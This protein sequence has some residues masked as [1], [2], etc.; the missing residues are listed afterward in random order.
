[1]SRDTHSGVQC[2]HCH[3]HLRLVAVPD[4]ASAP[5]PDPTPDPAP[6]PKAD[7]APVT[8]VVHARPAL[9]AQPPREEWTPPPVGEVLAQYAHLSKDTATARRGAARVRASLN[10]ARQ[11]AVKKRTQQR[12]ARSA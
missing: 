6:V 2:P 5:A 1:M 9:E 10:R 8:R 7:P 3:T 12:A 4:S 11:A